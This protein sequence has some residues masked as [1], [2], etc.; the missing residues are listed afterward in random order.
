LVIIVIIVDLVKKRIE[1]YG[2]HAPLP[3]MVQIIERVLSSRFTTVEIEHT[4]KPF[5]AMNGLID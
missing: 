2:Y 3:R 4:A 5:T 1:T